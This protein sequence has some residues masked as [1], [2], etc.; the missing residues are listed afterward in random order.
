MRR[1]DLVLAALPGGDGKPRPAPVVQDAA[2]ALAGFDSVVPCPLTSTLTDLPPCRVPVEPAPGTG[3]RARS[4]VMVE[5][6][7]AVSA[8]RPRDV[9]GRVDDAT[10]RA[11]ERALLLVL[12][13]RL[14]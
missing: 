9:I 2:V 1:G 5:K 10:M 3:L 6:L 11:A 13:I 4:E 7:T 8:K 12:G 14:P